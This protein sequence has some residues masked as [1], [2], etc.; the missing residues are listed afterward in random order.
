MDDFRVAARDKRR[1]IYQFKIKLTLPEEKTVDIIKSEQV[2]KTM[3]IR[4]K[5]KYFSERSA[6]IF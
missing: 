3:N 6:L 5:S 2:V 1:R 4:R